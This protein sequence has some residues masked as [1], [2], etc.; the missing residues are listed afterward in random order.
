MLEMYTD[1]VHVR[2]SF[3][4]PPSSSCRFE[5]STESGSGP[6]GQAVS[7]ETLRVKP[8]MSPIVCILICSLHQGP[9]IHAASSNH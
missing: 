7:L 5:V 4:N 2:S 8:E 1:S 6:R 3:H 9:E